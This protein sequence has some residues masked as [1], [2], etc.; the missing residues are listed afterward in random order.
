[1]ILSNLDRHKDLVDNEAT[2]AHISA[3]YEAR[4]AS[5]RAN[6]QN[7]KD[8]HIRQIRELK[9]WLAP[10][11]YETKQVAFAHIRKKNPDAGNWLLEDDR[12]K[13][14]V[15]PKVGKTQTPVLWLTGIPGSGNYCSLGSY[16]LL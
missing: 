13:T 9:E 4:K 7:E 16:P 2:A 10:V 3:A 15:D 1:M 6:K 8:R 14:W 5:L 11:L 12:F